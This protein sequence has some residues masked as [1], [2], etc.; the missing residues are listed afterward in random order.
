MNKNERCLEILEILQKE[1]KVE[2]G[3]LAEKFEISEMTIRRDLNALAQQY[4]ITRTHGGAILNK[5]QP[6]VRM[7]SFDEDRIANRDAKERIAEMAASMI[8]NG[9][10]IFIDA[11]STTRIILN[12]LPEDT[13]AVVVCNHLKVAEQAL[14]FNNLS[15]IMLGGDMIRITNCSSGPVAEEQLRKYQL[16]TAFIGAAA[17]GTDGKLYDGY[18]PEARLKSAIF[19]VAKRVYVLADSSKIN[20][21]DLNEFGKLTQLDGVI[22]DSG[23]DKEG[24]NLMK[25]HHVNVMLA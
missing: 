24:E 10:R 3:E 8:R 12:Y 6:V 7:I 13:K 23:M 19:E 11:G 2:V 9:Q 1:H 17:I 25:R 15:V 14:K 16:D 18:S 21:Y 4:N 22:T 5:N 20:T